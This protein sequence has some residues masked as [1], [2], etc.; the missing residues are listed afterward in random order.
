M[1]IGCILSIDTMT[2]GDFTYEELLA[3]VLRRRKERTAERRKAKDR[4]L[5]MANRDGRLAYQRA[6]YQ[7]HRDEICAKKRQKGR[8][9]LQM[10]SATAAVEK[11]RECL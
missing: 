2:L 5:Y 6:Y 1:K 4:Q 8:R 7:R 10:M 9:Y 3:E 11:D